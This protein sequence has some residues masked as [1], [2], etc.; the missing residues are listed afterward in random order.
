MSAE[1]NK[2]DSVINASY[3]KEES[4]RP[5]ITKVIVEKIES[6]P[7]STAGA[8]SGDFLQYRNLKKK[9]EAR[10][11]QMEIEYRQKLQQ[12]EFERIRNKHIQE[13]QEKTMKKS[14]K[15]KKKKERKINAKRFKDDCKKK[16]KIEENGGED[17]EINQEGKKQLG[18]GESESEKIEK[19]FDDG[20]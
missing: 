6:L 17:D 11:E 13:S 18:V 7:G 5:I 9:E 12:D 4:T 20:N 1:R 8:G 14:I 10:I 19:D 16:Q 2:K 15:R 3:A